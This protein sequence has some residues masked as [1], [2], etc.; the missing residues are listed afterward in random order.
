MEKEVLMRYLH[1][2]TEDLPVSINKLY[3]SRGGRRMMT[4]RGQRF[5]T[6]FVASR[7]GCSVENLMKFEGTKEDKYCLRLWFKMRPESLH[8]KGY[9]KDKRVK[10]LFKKVDV[11]NLVKL[12][13]DCVSELTGI[14]DRNNW[15]VICQKVE[16]ENEGVDAL[17][18]ILD[19]EHEQTRG[20]DEVIRSI[21]I[22]SGA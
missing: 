14:D 1:F 8:A 2:R 12:I 3:Y 20:V 9:G 10:Y 17:L 13:E 16:D 6:H 19:K 21:E 4:A 15:V 5:K 18:E 11:S 22:A 7:G